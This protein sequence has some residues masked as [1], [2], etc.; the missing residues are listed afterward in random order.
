[1]KKKVTINSKDYTLKNV[2]FNGICELEDLGLSID[3]LRKSK[4]NACRA[5]LAYHGDMT[6]EEAGT[7]IMEHLKNGGEFD[8][9]SPMIEALVNS[10]FF[11]AIRQPNKTA[12]IT[13]G[14]EPSQA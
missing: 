5:L 8:D 12:K 4:M 13:T 2:D 3:T 1:M 14:E 6:A 9:F 10:D 11:Q 7:Q